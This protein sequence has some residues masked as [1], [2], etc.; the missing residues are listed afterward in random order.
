MS[1]W[2]TWKFEQK[3]N[4]IYVV[5]NCKLWESNKLEGT[6]MLVESMPGNEVSTEKL[7]FKF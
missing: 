3:R 5:I 1:N 7:C 2:L 4:F 6:W